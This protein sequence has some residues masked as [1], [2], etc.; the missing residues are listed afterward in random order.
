M[1]KLV[2]SAALTTAIFGIS[3]AHAGGSNSI[4]S[5]TSGGG[6]TTSGFYGGASI[7]STFKDNCSTT[8]NSSY[9]SCKRERDKTAWKAFG[10]YKVAPNI[11][12]EG[13]YI[14]FGEYS[15]LKEDNTGT[16]WTKDSATAKGVSLMGVASTSVA[17]N[18][19]VF[20]KLGVL[21]WKRDS[22]I[23]TSVSSSP[24]SITTDT[25]NDLAVG[26]GASINVNENIA[27]RGEVEHF[28]DLD[29]NFVSLGASFSTF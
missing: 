22:W 4:F 23:T 13:A 1:K 16:T 29:V 17:D 21:H 3:T 18:I 12:V 6:A 25:G 15:N 5:D 14:D 2:L 28:S 24:S 20:G 8:A 19:D 26:A 7:A 27:V 10:G 9:A 11:A